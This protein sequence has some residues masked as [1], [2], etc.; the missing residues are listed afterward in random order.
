MRLN[1]KKIQLFLFIILVGVIFS[2]KSVKTRINTGNYEVINAVLQTYT[3]NH[4]KAFLNPYPYKSRNRIIKGF[5]ERY[6]KSSFYKEMCDSTI[7]ESVFSEK[8]LSNYKT[9]ARNIH[10]IDLNKIEN[11]RVIKELNLTRE[12]SIINYNN[13]QGK[14]KN[15]EELLTWK[16]FYWQLENNYKMLKISEPYFSSDLRFAFCFLYVSQESDFIYIMEKKN[17]QWNNVCRLRLNYY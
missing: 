15:P 3:L 10:K 6:K 4:K 17:S 11:Q 13:R 12:N 1:L 8:E 16:Y 14:I 2:C 9:I 7:L 5:F